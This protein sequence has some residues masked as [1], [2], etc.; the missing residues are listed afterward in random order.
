MKN[1]KDDFTWNYYLYYIVNLTTGRTCGEYDDL[2]MAKA[3]C[4]DKNNE[5]IYKYA[6]QQQHMTARIV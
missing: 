6:V 1:P 3:V 2:S 4:R 5:M